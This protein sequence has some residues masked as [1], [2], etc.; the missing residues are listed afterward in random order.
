MSLLRVLHDF[1]DDINEMIHI[2]PNLLDKG[3]SLLIR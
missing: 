2:S 3:A 1:G